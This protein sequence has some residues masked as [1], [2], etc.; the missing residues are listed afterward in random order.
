MVPLWKMSALTRELKQEPIKAKNRFVF[1]FF[2]SW[3][4][5]FSCLSWKW[6]M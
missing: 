1:F 4:L 6:I 5:F 3:S 2:G